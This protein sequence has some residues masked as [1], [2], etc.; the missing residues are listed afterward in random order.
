MG[1][2]GVSPWCRELAEKKHRLTGAEQQA[3]QLEKLCQDLK[4]QN[5]ALLLQQVDAT[6]APA[7]RA[8]CYASVEELERVNQDLLKKYILYAKLNCHPILDNVDEDKIAKM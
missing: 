2:W 3:A 8:V 6:H 1:A 4:K 5:H 7:D